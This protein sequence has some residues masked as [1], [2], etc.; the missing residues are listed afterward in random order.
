MI[1]W[2][3]VP[4][5]K[6]HEQAIDIRKKISEKEKRF[7]D[8]LGSVYIVV[9]IALGTTTERKCQKTEKLHQTTLQLKGTERP[10]GRQKSKKPYFIPFGVLLACCSL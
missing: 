5:K 9:K 1:H 3:R 4:F 2:G 8:V 10:K 6:G 7:T